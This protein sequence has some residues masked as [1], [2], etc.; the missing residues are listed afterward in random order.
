M[1]SLA[2]MTPQPYIQDM[3]A[4]NP[5]MLLHQHNMCKQDNRDRLKGCKNLQDL[6]NFKVKTIAD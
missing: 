3:M 6:V 1:T 2:E 4:S 5:T